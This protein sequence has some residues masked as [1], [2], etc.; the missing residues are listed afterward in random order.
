MA[1]AWVGW[2][3]DVVSQS[4]HPGFSQL[5]WIQVVILWEEFRDI[6]ENRSFE[7]LR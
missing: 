4:W 3:I 1:V 2:H 5:I 6:F 7:I